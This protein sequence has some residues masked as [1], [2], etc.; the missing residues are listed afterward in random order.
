MKSKN[1]F[2]RAFIDLAK[3]GRTDWRSVALAFLIVEFLVALFGIT[4]GIAVAPP[5][6]SGHHPF[7]VPEADKTIVFPLAES[8]GYIFG[9][10]LVCVKV[11]RR[12]F[13]SLISTDMTFRIRRFLLGAGLYLVANVISFAAI[14]LFTSLRYGAWIVIPRHFEWP[15][16]EYGLIFESMV[17]L[18][19]IPILAFAEELWFRAWLTQT[20]G[21]YIRSTLIVVLLVALLFAHAH[22]DYNLRLKTLIFADSLG[23]S[24]L[25]LRDQRLELAFGAH[26]MM[27][28][29]A[30]LMALFFTGPLPQGNVPETSFDFVTLVILKG[31]LP[32]VLMYGILQKTEGWF[33]PIVAHQ[34]S[35]C[36]V[37]L[38]QLGS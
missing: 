23:L 35:L 36:D 5:V 12:P 17:K 34:A 28:V 1:E 16:H 22:S 31:V 8:A 19:I 32:F 18:L 6:P 14:S 4:T 30:M 24:A 26:S 15:P 20:L 25:S 27:N 11:L 29:C 21:H 37:R 38:R 10:W 13:R 33:N 2:S 9:L 3:M 7:K